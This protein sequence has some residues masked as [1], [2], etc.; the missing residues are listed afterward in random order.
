MERVYSHKTKKLKRKTRASLEIK[1]RGGGGLNLPSHSVSPWLWLWVSSFRNFSYPII[2]LI[3][4]QAN[5]ALSA[6]ILRDSQP[7]SL[8]Q[9]LPRLQEDNLPH[10]QENSPFRYLGRNPPQYCENSPVQCYVDQPP[11]PAEQFNPPQP[12]KGT[13]S[14]STC[15]QPEG[16]HPIQPQE[17]SATLPHSAGGMSQCHTLMVSYVTRSRIITIGV[18]HIDIMAERAY[19]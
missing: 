12:Y 7:L 6:S 11:D 16:E 15:A 3:H 9:D 4:E 13:D 14:E 19:R 8:P 17:L 2:A 18:C 5:S 10:Y 1:G